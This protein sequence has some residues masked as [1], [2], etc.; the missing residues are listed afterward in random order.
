MLFQNNDSIVRQ[1]GGLIA[2]SEQKPP[3]PIRDRFSSVEKNN[4]ILLTGGMNSAREDTENMEPN[5]T[6]DNA[7]QHHYKSFASLD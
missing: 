1:E 4:R 2:Y 3:A 5:R 6:F 7:L